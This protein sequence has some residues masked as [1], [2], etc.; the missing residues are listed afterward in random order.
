[1]D[2]TAQAKAAKKPR[3]AKKS[4]TGGA[5][6]AAVG[7]TQIAWAREAVSA[8]TLSARLRRDPW[9]RASVR[10]PLAVQKLIIER[11]V[12]DRRTTGDR[13]L[14]QNHYI[15]AALSQ[16]PPKLGDAVA[17][18][19]AWQDFIGTSRSPQTAGRTMLLQQQVA[20]AME[21]LHDGLLVV[22]GTGM[23]GHTQAWAMIR[24]LAALDAA[25][26]GEPTEEAALERVLSRLGRPSST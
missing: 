24:L 21:Q 13:K 9:P 10:I 8:S 11:M 12:L 2:D 26:A 4:S 22:V 19:R 7:G 25:D 20:D 6:L 5:G 18:A 3:P 17:W 1:M 16:I 14:A 15:N 23:L